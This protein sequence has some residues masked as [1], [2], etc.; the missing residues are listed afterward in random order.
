VFAR[1]HWEDYVLGR[2]ED[3]YILDHVKKFDN[4]KKPGVGARERRIIC[5]R[6]QVAYKNACPLKSA[7]SQEWRLQ[8]LVDAFWAKLPRLITI[9]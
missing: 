1:P 2:G 7:V 4:R 3:L 9:S 8:R 6:D 5:Q